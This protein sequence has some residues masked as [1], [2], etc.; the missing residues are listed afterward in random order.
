MVT[1]E[2]PDTGDIVHK[3]IFRYRHNLDPANNL[4]HKEILLMSTSYA[5]L[6]LYVFVKNDI[7]DYYK[8]RLLS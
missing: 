2:E 7:L 5:Y 8:I 3:T 1:K 6:E 4:S